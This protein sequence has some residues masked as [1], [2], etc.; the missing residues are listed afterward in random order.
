M[1]LLSR[2]FLFC[3]RVLPLI[4]LSAFVADDRLRLVY[5]DRIFFPSNLSPLGLLA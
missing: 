1:S 4:F 3:S 2:L 5:G